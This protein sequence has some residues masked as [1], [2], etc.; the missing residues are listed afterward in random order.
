M[1][2]PVKCIHVDNEKGTVIKWHSI[3][4]NTVTH[5]A[6][7]IS[8]SSFAYSRI[9]LRSLADKITMQFELV[10]I[11]MYNKVDIRSQFS[12]SKPLY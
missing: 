2:I 6:Y 3:S 9:N 8:I 5:G 1:N 11:Y 7:N 10:C 4:A 12:L